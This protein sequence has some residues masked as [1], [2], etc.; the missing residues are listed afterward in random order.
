MPTQIVKKALS[1]KNLIEKSPQA[2]ARE[3]LH[4]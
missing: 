4:T 1:T 3:P 2:K